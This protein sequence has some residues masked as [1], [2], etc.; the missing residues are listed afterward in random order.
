MSTRI[1]FTAK[2]GATASGEFASP[3]GTGPAGG[4]VLIQEWWG[5]N[6]HI[7][8]LV[9]R[10]ADAG[11]NVLAPDLY[12][13]QIATDPKRAEEMMNALDFA[14]A[15][16]EV[17]GAVEHLRAAPRSTGKVAIMGFCMGGAVTLAAAAAIPALDAAV[18]FYGIPG[19]ADFTKIKAPV[20]GHFAKR[21]TF[22]PVTKAEEV[23]RQIESA[24]GSMEL[25]VYDAQHAFVND[26]RP[27][28]YDAANAKL[29][30]DRSIAFLRKRL[31]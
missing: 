30:W 5:V 2:S 1:D 9:A 10:L 21:D 19:A 16:D 14:K 25:E 28:V 26:T 13:G 23:K 29:A 17:A 15:V 11:F 31:S 8:S 3:D 7:Q 12:H 27:E 18:P 6:A 22:V 20:L 24:G 4:V